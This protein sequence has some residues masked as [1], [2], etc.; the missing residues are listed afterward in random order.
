METTKNQRKINIVQKEEKNYQ[1]VE[2]NQL[3]EKEL[4][5]KQEQIY[6]EGE[7]H[8]EHSGE[9][10]SIN[11]PIKEETPQ[12]KVFM[13]RVNYLNEKISTMKYDDNLIKNIKKDLGTQVENLE[14][15]IEEKKIVIPETSKDIKKYIERSNSTQNNIIK[16]SNKDYELK[17]KHKIMK[18]LKEEQ[19]LL[20]SRLNKIEVNEKLLNNEGFMNLNN[21]SEG[22]TKYDKSIKEQQARLNKNKKNEI[23][24]RLKEIELRIDQMLEKEKTSYKLTKQQ[25]LD[26]YIDNYERDKEIIEERAR[27]YLKETKNKQKIFEKENKQLEEE[28]KKKLE[29]EEK[30]KQQIIKEFMDKE[31]AIHRKR[32]KEQE[33]KILEYKPYINAKYTK[34][35]NDYL[36]GIYD[37]NYKE[38]EE[39]L[40]KKVNEQRKMKNKTVTKEELEDFLVDIEKKKEQLKIKKEKR[41]K[42]ELEKFE[43]ARNY[44]PSYVSKF[45]EMTDNEVI[46]NLE[47][48]KIKKD[49]IM[50]F[51]NQKIECA[52]KANKKYIIDEKLKKERIERIVAIEN[53]KLV[54]IKYTLKKNEK[55]KQSK[56]IEKKKPSWFDK[57]EGKLKKMNNSAVF[58]NENELIKKPKRNPF[59]LS[60]S[61]KK[62]ENKKDEKDAENSNNKEKNKPII[63]IDYLNVLREERQKRLLTSD[64]KENDEIKKKKLEEKKKNKLFNK[65]NNI[66]ENIYNI[67]Q[68]AEELENKAK[69]GEQLLK[70]SG[71]IKNHPEEGKKVTG[72]FID[73]IKTK[74]YLLNEVYK[75]K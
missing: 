45:N 39:K 25:R 12:T 49:E 41:D 48:E 46:N 75:E 28:I 66:I 24:E 29:E 67:K 20:K 11:P 69:M 64:D 44:K 51:R 47:K 32:I 22:L 37:K 15:Q 38:K 72:Y 54:Q 2:N 71:G 26:N 34:T 18:E 33:K 23:K 8:I 10:E 21:S 56:L 50:L 30:K 52:K 73:S 9:E 70:H 61:K 19:A 57:F 36:F 62:V 13:P 16:Y 42:E 27:R 53:P 6:I 58:E 68:K 59:P 55:L 63:K 4:S 1:N 17:K 35:E 14:R 31:Q 43:M 40:I 74:L 60:L 3:K 65:E 7:P 5:S